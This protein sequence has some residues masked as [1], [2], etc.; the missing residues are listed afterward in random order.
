M[1]NIKEKENQEIIDYLIEYKDKLKDIAETETICYPIIS[2]H[3]AAKKKILIKN[4]LLHPLILKTISF[5]KKR[6]TV[7]L[8]ELEN[9]LATVLE[10]EILN[11]DTYLKNDELKQV[12]KVH[13]SLKKK[14]EKNE[15][16]L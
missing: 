1:V 7:E 12:I 4:L 3:L 6:K 10:F 15:N 16:R 5:Y 11:K 13:K 2:L 8:N 14:S 9:L